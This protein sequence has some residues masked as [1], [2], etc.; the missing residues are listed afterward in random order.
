MAGRLIEAGHE[1]TLWNRT[2]SKAEAYRGRARIAESPRDVA[3]SSDAVIT[4]VSTPEALSRTLFGEEGV[5]SG[6]RPGTTLIDMST[7]GPDH[8]AEVTARLP[9]GVELID[10]PVLGSVSNAADGTLKVFVGA[11]EGS[12]ARWREVFGAM[13]FPLHLGPSGSGAAMKLVAN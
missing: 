11:S 3:R 7:V 13:G 9:E 6:M 10:A 5:V 12:F 8:I 2:L 4:M 1:L